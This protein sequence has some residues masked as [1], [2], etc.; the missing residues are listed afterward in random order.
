MTRD[1]DLWATV[2]EGIS[3]IS[4]L[5]R[6][7]DGKYSIAILNNSVQF[8]HD[9][10]G[11]DQG[12]SVSAVNAL[13]D[14]TILLVGD[15]GVYRINQKNL[16]QEL[17]FENTHQEIPVKNGKYTYDWIWEPSKI[18]MIDETSYFITGAFGGVYLLSK[19]DDGQFRFVSLDERPGDPIVW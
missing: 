11:S 1:G 15:R 16:V 13:Q 3:R 7:K 14:G 2:G 4:L 10:F 8:T 19:G 6:S 18:L 17:S 9:L 5:H 12:L